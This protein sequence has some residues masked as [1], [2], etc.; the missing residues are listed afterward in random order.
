MYLFL[1][2]QLNV[3]QLNAA[4]NDRIILQPFYKDI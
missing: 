4:G 2:V 3:Q 1:T